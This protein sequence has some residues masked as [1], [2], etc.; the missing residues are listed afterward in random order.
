MAKYNAD[1]DIAE[2]RAELN[3]EYLIQILQKDGSTKLVGF[4]RL[5]MMIGELHAIHYCVKA[6]KAYAP[7]KC[8]N[9]HSGGFQVVFYQR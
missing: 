1:I 8:F 4:T 9:Y 3:R 7:K 6:L 2:L 5:C